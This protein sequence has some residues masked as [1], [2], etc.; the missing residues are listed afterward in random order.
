MSIAF[1]PTHPSR[2]A[3][4]VQYGDVS[5]MTRSCFTL[6]ASTTIGSGRGVIFGKRRLGDAQLSGTDFVRV[7]VPVPSSRGCRI[8]GAWQPSVPP[9]KSKVHPPGNLN[10]VV[11][12]LRYEDPRPR[13]VRRPTAPVS[14]RV[15]SCRLWRQNRRMDCRPRIRDGP[16]QCRAAFKHLACHARMAR[17]G[18]ASKLISGPTGT[19]P[20]GLMCRWLM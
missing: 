19:M 15:R 9:E 2:P 16:D 1:I 14:S 11:T 3:L 7:L 6:L 8:D 12:V 4:A 10:Q 20:V 13:R 17:P 5:S 18:G